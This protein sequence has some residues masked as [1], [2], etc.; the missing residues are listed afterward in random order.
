MRPA[1]AL[2]FGLL[3]GRMAGGAEKKGDESMHDFSARASL[4]SRQSSAIYASVL[5]AFLCLSTSAAEAASNDADLMTTGSVVQNNTAH[6]IA[7]EIVKPGSEGLE[8]TARL[9]DTGGLIERDIAW[10]LRDAQGSVVY[11][12]TSSLANLAVQPG[13]YNVEATYGSAHFSQDL[14]VLPANHLMVSFVLNVGGIRVLPRLKNIDLTATDSET[15]IYAMSGHA[16]GKL[17]TISKTPGEI[18]RVEA[19]DYRVESRFSAGNAV[20]IADVH[21]KPGLMSAIEI[22]H[23]AGLARLAYVGAPD[24]HVSWQ[25]TDQSGEALAA[26]EGLSVNVVLKPGTYVAKASI[27]SEMLTANFVIIEGQA[28]D[29]MLG[30]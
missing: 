26:I 18:L 22:D 24:A 19:G 25:V 9:S 13:D 12:G 30:N 21:V 2:C 1:V 11:E 14:T 7:I 27:G 20:A 8:L 16:K 17:I 10:K 3:T 15:F 5:A 4:R 6:E 23:A 28:R 29:I